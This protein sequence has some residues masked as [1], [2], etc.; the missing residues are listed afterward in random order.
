MKIV[1]FSIKRR[2][3][4]AMIITAMVVFGLASYDRLAVNLLP[5]VSYPSLTIRTE[6]TGVAPGEIENLLSIRVEEAVG[7]VNNV[8]RVSSISR[9][10]RSDVIVEFNWGTNMD[11]AS[12]DVRE[13]L[14]ML[15]LPLDAQ[16][17]ILLRFDPSLDPIMRLG[18]HGDISLTS[19]RV[20]A[21]EEIK[22]ELE[23]IEGVAAARV[24]GGLEEEIQVEIDEGLLTS[25]GIPIAQVTSKLAQEN[26]NLT[27]GTLK[28]GDAEFLVRTLNQFKTVEEI[29]DIVI[30][31]KGKA[32]IKLSNIG[33]AFIGHKERSIIARINGKENLEIAI[34]KE[35]EANTVAVSQKVREKLEKL[36]KG[37][38]RGLS[39][40]LQV[41]IITD[42]SRFIKES[43]SEVL[44]TAILGGILAIIVLYFF[45]RNLQSTVII[46]L[47]IP[48][49][50][51]TTFFF[52]Y[53]AGISLNIMSLGGL[54]LG[55]GM[56][57]DNSIVVLESIS[58]FREKGLSR[59]KASYRGASIV[60]KAV[61]A[62]TL[63]TICV[64]FQ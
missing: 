9:T 64:F 43:I 1:A 28:D 26:I 46:G 63:T 24:S 15:K 61:I 35:S 22:R 38:L 13:K 52:M 4:V 19:L 32:P 27:V 53:L 55:I 58:R 17:P 34:Y 20:Y 5:D 59:R 42:Q 60:G 39:S 50:V 25:L 2:V 62:S 44:T 54:A 47:A 3:T 29:N 31:F 18:L 30:G 6:Y 33:R 57:V 10:G 21:E 11:F 40:S 56:L 51:I 8:R 14:D 48:V 37:R 23:S 36:L 16:K 49:S 12:L 45:L 41:D 7:V